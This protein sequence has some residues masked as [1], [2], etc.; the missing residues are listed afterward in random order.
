MGKRSSFERRALDYYPTPRRAVDPLIPHLRGIRKFAEPCC[1]DGA[2]IRHLES[3]GLRCIYQGD[4]ADGRD[5]LATTDYGDVASRVRPG[6][7]FI[8]T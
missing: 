2:L 3:F 6:R 5:A 8:Q 1:G 4:I 7:H